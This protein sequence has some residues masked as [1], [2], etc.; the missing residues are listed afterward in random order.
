MGVN[1]SN[2]PKHNVPAAKIALII[3]FTTNSLTS[4]SSPFSIV[5]VT[6]FSLICKSTDSRTA[7]SGKFFSQDMTFQTKDARSIAVVGICSPYG[8]Q[9]L[10]VEIYCDAVCIARLPGRWPSA[11]RTNLLLLPTSV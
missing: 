6:K 10:R 2:P 1:A 3:F 8:K 5:S 7:S 4:I 9:G 11:K